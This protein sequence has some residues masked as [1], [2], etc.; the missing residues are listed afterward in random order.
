[1]LKCICDSEHWTYN[2]GDRAAELIT[3]VS[4][5]GLFTHAFDRG[6]FSYI[7]MMKS[8]LPEIRNNA[9]AHGEGIDA[10]AVSE[11][12]AKYALN[13]SAANLLFVGE[14]YDLLKNGIQ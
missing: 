7:A 9:G 3:V 5:A 13:V 6:F 1:M 4:K 10:Q 2:P 14:C 12:I 11:Q 8:G